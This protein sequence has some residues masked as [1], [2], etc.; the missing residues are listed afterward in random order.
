MDK[1]VTFRPDQVLAA[2]GT[3]AP[4]FARILKVSTCTVQIF[5]L[6]QNS[7]PTFLA[8]DFIRNI[9]TINTW[10]GVKHQYPLMGL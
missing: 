4:K 8:F 5:L 1:S 2:S 3:Y 9:R 6:K 7:T 10:L